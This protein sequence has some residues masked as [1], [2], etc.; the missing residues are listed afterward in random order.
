MNYAT[1]PMPNR[2]TKQAQI[3]Q[4]A[5]IKLSSRN[6]KL[7]ALFSYFLSYPRKAGIELGG[8]LHYAAHEDVVAGEGADIR[9][10]AELIWRS[11]FDGSFSS[12]VN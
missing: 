2:A 12:V 11:E 4:L 5:N 7:P 6:M 10:V 1:N 3:D 9:I 8:Y